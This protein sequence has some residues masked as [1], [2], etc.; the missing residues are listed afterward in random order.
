MRRIYTCLLELADA[1]S[2]APRVARALTKRW[3]GRAYGGWPEHAPERW[4]PEPGVTVRWRLLDHPHR[5]DE[6]FELVWT[7]PHDQDPTLWRRATVQI[8]TTS[9]AGRILILEQLE[10]ADPKVR[11][12]PASRV[13]RPMLV[14]EL[15][16]EVACVD[17]GWSVAAV[18]HRVGADRAPELDAFVRGDRR[19]PVV[20]VA[21]DR[22]GV[23]R[24]DAARFADEL[25]AVAHVVVLDGP[26]AV[27]ALDAE[28]GSGRGA[29]DGGVR[30]LWPSWRSSDPP[31]HHPVWRAEEVSGPEGPRPRVAEILADLVLGAA[32][33]RVEG[34]PLV[35]L[36]ARSQDSV[37]LQERRVELESLRTA[38]LDDRAAAEELITEYQSELSRADEQ[39][40]LLEADLE[41][42]RELRLRF[43]QGYL[44]LATGGEPAAGPGIGGPTNGAA[45][46]L[47]AVVRRAK[48]LHPHLVILPEAER[49]A[50]EWRFDR[51]DLVELDL[52]RLDA[53]AAEWASGAL[54]ADFGTACRNQGL[55]WVRDVSASAKQKYAEDY[56]RSYRGRP[57]MLGPH[58]R[59]DGRQL[60]RVY[61]FL[62]ED[63][64]R[65]IVGHVGRHLRDRTT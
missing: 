12:A 26:D 65:V 34:D 28:L 37:D 30:L 41:R 64:R 56:Q 63:E 16:R 43:E 31:A 13:R 6:A 11:A 44:T 24:A 14:S 33:L 36:L 27:A 51:V 17:G 61:C 62:D 9:D 47:G 46:N 52:A 21:P 4:A 22:N 23:V 58:F 35:E 40:Y 53:V 57:I 15:V 20:L 19:L 50:S 1:S 10:S 25:V 59:R 5:I 42:E 54:R 39:V 3:V 8:T 60:V 38:V 32:T 49:S 45:S 2:A 48:E 55:D 7:R 29:P 18:P